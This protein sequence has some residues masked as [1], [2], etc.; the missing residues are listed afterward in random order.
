[1]LSV[2][3]CLFL[4]GPVIRRTGGIADE[5]GEEADEWWPAPRP[6]R[7]LRRMFQFAENLQSARA[8]SGM[9]LSIKTGKQKIVL[10]IVTPWPCAL[11]RFWGK[12]R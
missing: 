9:L 5:M 4:R 12:Y 6:L 2:S 11:N 10:R 8:G 3:A 1:M 7:G